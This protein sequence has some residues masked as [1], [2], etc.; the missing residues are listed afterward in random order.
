MNK[1]KKKLM[2]CKLCS[3]LEKLEGRKGTLWTNNIEVIIKDKPVTL[4]L[5]GTQID[6]EVLR[7]NDDYIIAFNSL[8]KYAD[9]N[10]IVMPK[11]HV[12]NEEILNRPELI[13]KVEKVVFKI[14]QKQYQ[15]HAR[16]IHN[17]GDKYAS[18]PDHYHKQVFCT[19]GTVLY[20]P[21]FDIRKLPITEADLTFFKKY[22]IKKH[23]SPE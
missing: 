15:G 14:I 1:L 17:Y 16:V 8:G 12:S 7:F 3:L 4:E 20:I 6:N 22:L 23:K 21:P 19:K 5:T 10:I 2:E 18:V 13:Q 9:D 11:E